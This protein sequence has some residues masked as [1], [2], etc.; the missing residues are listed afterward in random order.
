M[1]E[2]TSVNS[3]S[4]PR[5]RRTDTVWNGLQ[6]VITAGVVMATL[7]TMWTPNS[8]FSNQALEGL[9][10]SWQEEPA[11]VSAAPTP[12]ARPMAR[13]GIVAGHKG[14]DSGA[15]CADGLREV[16]VNER[17]AKLVQGQL[18]N[19]GYQVDL[20][21]EFDPDLTG[22]QAAVL[23][24]IHN[25]TCDP[26]F[27]HLTGYKVAAAKSSAYPEKARRLEACLITRY[28]EL[29]G[30]PYHADTITA[31][32]T[33]YHTFREIHTDTTAAIIETGFLLSDRQILTEQPDRVAAGITAG[34]LC[35]IRNESLPTD[36]VP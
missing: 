1:S 33:D 32:M 3:A 8:L 5:R 13:I 6:S 26:Q 31:D 30:L 14:N 35:Y 15:V 22:Y 4:R 34:V 24:S 16:D 11:V 36:A 23:V 21:D 2:T 25:D 9:F 17:I 7:F 20:L 27:E 19:E 29:T 12:T 18:T 10:N 28:G